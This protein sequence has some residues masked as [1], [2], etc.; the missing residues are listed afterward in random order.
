MLMLNN[1]LKNGGYE[2]IEYNKTIIEDYNI[3]DYVYDYASEIILTN[4]YKIIDK[5]LVMQY[6]N[7]RNKEREL[8]IMKYEVRLNNAYL[9]SFKNY[10]EACELRDAI[11][12]R[13]PKAKVEIIQK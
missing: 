5:Q 8:I 1:N 6:N 3:V 7:Y 11:Q 12:K 13:F 4:Y 2:V 9:N 10:G